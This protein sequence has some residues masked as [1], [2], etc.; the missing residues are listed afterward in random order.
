[1]RENYFKRMRSK[2]PLKRIN[3]YLSRYRADTF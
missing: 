3:Y 2:N 1:M